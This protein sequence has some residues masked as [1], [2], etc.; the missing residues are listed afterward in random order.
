MSKDTRKSQSLGSDP[1]LQSDGTLPYLLRLRERSIQLVDDDDE[2]PP[3]RP[4]N[5]QSSA[6]PDLGPP[7]PEVPGYDEGDEAAG[8]LDRLAG[9]LLERED[10]E[11]IA[12][13]ISRHDARHYDSFG[14]NGRVARRA[15]AVFK[16]LHE[17]YFRVESHGHQVIPEKEGAILAANHGG[18][19]PFDAAMIVVDIMLRAQPSRLA[20][21]VVDRWAGKLPFV[22][23]FYARVGQVIGSRENFGALLRDDQLVL[24]FPEGMAGVR[25]RAAERYVL[26]DF[27]LGFVE[28]SLKY[29]VPIIPVAV[30]GADDQAP[31]LHNS[32]T[33]AKLLGLPFF[34]I[35]PTFP[36]LGPLGLLP[37]PVKYEILYGDPFRFYEEF[38]VTAIKDPHAIRY[39]AEQVRR[40]IQ[41]TL[42]QR[43]IARRSKRL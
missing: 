39:M 27:H 19:L 40:R 24:V 31:I 43:V 4:T 16:Q 8:I 32:K 2:P 21:S 41:V 42:D 9:V 33:L 22:N 6:P 26:Q 20:R 37:Y 12:S 11:R 30:V 25:K 13:L 1:F 38:P 23:V 14:L 10:E 34:P 3:R 29:R 5:R 15:L 36:L 17:N 35:T 28:E 18:L 7:V